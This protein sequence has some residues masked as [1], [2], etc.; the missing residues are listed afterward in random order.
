[1]DFDMQDYSR[2]RRNVGDVYNI[3]TKYG[4]GATVNRAYF[5]FI[6]FNKGANADIDD[7]LNVRYI[8]TDKTLDSNYVFKDSA[9]HLNLYERKNYYPRVYWKSQLGKRGGEIEE[10]NK[11][12]IQPLA[13]SDL[14]QKFE[15]DCKTR[16][17]LILSEND[18]PGWKCYDNGKRTAIYPAAIR[19]YPPLFR[20][21]ALDKGHHIVEFK[22]NKPFYWF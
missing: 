2:V 18:Y 7:L 19:N 20:S 22:Y 8:L 11:S 15:V 1:V 21:I 6:N 4:Y 17:T 16:D 3:Q 10:E 12:T 13:Y 14:Y 9:R 5:D